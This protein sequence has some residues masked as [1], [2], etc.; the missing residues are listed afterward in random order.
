MVFER[1]LESLRQLR[2][3]PLTAFVLSGGGN[4]GAVQVGM[5]RA[6]VEHEIE[7]DLIV[8]CSV[9]AVNGAAFAAEPDLDGVRRLERIWTR[10]ADGD[11]DI[12]PNR[13]F[14]PIAVQMGRRGHS[15][16]TQDRL[17]QLLEDE[18][19]ARSFDDLSIPFACIATDLD[20][21]SEYWFDDGELVPALLA[22]SALPGLYPPVSVNGR[23][24]FDGG[25]VNEVPIHRATDLGA[26]TIYLLHVGHLDDRAMDDADRPFDVLAHAYWTARANRLDDELSRLPST[27]TLHRLPAG[28][29]PKLRFDDFSEGRALM[30][31]A[32]RASFAALSAAQDSA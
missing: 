8:G 21:A 30:D 3:T 15:V 9:G 12:M 24:L 1:L 31:Q 17:R 19:T 2:G 4:L 11:P 28:L 13:R 27:V 7:P 32:H 29:V 10:M 22:S 14:M 26:T 16:Y 6:L 5:L 23:R 18:L 20:R 25:V